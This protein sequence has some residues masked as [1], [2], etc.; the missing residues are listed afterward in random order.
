MVAE[1]FAQILG[2]HQPVASLFLTAQALGP[3]PSFYCHSGSGLGLMDIASTAPKIK[4]PLRANHS[5]ADL[6]S[7][8]SSPPALRPQLTRSQ[9]THSRNSSASSVNSAI[10]PH[11]LNPSSLRH[12]LPVPIYNHDQEADIGEGFSTSF[13]PPHYNHLSV[14]LCHF[15]PYSTPALDLQRSHS[16]SCTPTSLSDEEEASSRTSSSDVLATGTMF[17]IDTDI[18]E[19]RGSNKRSSLSPD[20]LAKFRQWMVGFCVVN[21]DLE[22]GQG[23]SGFPCVPKNA[24]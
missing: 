5:A 3:T 12:T 23:N 15:E 4:S 6:L 16:G 20:I 8:S 21:F 22:I 14:G 13:T 19:L 18:T 7:Q 2:D 10:H 11:S 24:T 1:K 17:E 9:S